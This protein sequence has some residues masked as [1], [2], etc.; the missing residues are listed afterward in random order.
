MTGVTETELMAAHRRPVTLDDLTGPDRRRLMHERIRR[1][2]AE[3]GRPVR[4]DRAAAGRDVE[5]EPRAAAAP[6]SASSR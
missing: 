2:E 5:D 4:V 3:R 1:V 6:R